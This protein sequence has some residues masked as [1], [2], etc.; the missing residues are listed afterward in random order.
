MAKWEETSKRPIQSGEHSPS[1]RRSTT[2]PSADPFE[3]DTHA[4]SWAQMMSKWASQE[5]Q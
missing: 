4:A 1:K 2:P 5:K 3:K